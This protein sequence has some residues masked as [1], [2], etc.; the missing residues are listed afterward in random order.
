MKCKRLSLLKLQNGTHTKKKKKRDSKKSPQETSTK[1]K[2]KP[3]KHKTK[4]N[5]DNEKDKK[6]KKRNRSEMKH[7][8]VLSDK[9]NDE[10]VEDPKPKKRRLTKNIINT[11][12]GED[13]LFG[14]I[15]G[16]NSDASH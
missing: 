11:N 3:E 9:E 2:K 14:D 16:D 5:K 10:F 4:S 8:D 12:E 6:I 1:K 13:D 15:I 7:A